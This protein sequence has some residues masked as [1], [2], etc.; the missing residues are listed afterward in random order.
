MST[1]NEK[2]PSAA[3][4]T[5][6]WAVIFVLL[7]GAVVANAM[8]SDLP[9]YARA[10]GVIVI[11]ALAGALAATT[12]KGKIAINFARESRTEVRKVV[13]PTRQE[14]INT[15]FIVLAAS[16]LMALVLWGLDGILVRLVGLLTGVI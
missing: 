7:A 11:I 6:K 10:A 9:V 16:A 15:T 3:A 1:V 12:V 2:Q 8:F 13:W 14:S 4:D 5:L